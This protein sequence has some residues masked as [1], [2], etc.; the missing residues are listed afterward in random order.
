MAIQIIRFLHPQPWGG[1]SAPLGIP[2]TD[3]GPNIPGKPR[4]F[5]PHVG[6]VSAYKRRCDEIAARG[7]E[8]PEQLTARCGVARK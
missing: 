2:R 3:V 8:P 5:M 4:V 1:V 7:Y 6:G